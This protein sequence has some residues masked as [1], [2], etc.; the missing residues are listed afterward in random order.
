M[1]RQSQEEQQISKVRS[2]AGKTG[3]AARWHNRPITEGNNKPIT[4]ITASSA[5]ASASASAKE[6]EAS[7]KKEETKAKIR[8]DALSLFEYYCQ[9]FQKHLNFEVWLPNI[10]ARLKK[11]DLALLKECVDKMATSVWHKENAQQGFE[12]I[13]SSDKRV[14][15]WLERE[16]ARP[17]EDPDAL[18]K[19]TEQR[20]E[21]MV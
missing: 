3:M 7:K 5:S 4:K 1:Y 19:K 17:E 16:K 2:E 6:D 11:Y 8:A 9:K 20:L 18:L 21:E 10:E 13:V 12:L 14:E 15:K